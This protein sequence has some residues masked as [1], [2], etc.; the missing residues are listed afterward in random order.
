[1]KIIKMAIS[2]NGHHRIT[3]CVFALALAAYVSTPARAD[4]P[5]AEI[6][7]PE[8]GRAIELGDEAGDE[9]GEVPLTD[10]SDAT[11]TDSDTEAKK[12]RD[13]GCKV[14]TMSPYRVDAVRT[15]A[16]TR[17]CNT[18]SWLDSLFGD[19]K[20]FKGKEFRGKISLGF[21]QDELDGFEP[22]LRVRIKTDLPNVSDRLSA[23]V[24][25]VDDD[26]YIS[27]TE[28]KGDRVNNVGL[29]SSDNAESE[30]LIGLGY[31]NPDKNSNGF[32]TSIGA[33][34]SSGLAPYAKVAYRYLF[35]PSE[36]HY[37]H[38]T[39]TVFWRK[40]DKSGVSSKLDYTYIIGDHDIMEWD[41]NI[42]YTEAAEQWEWITSTTWH[43][44]FTPT[45]GI[46]SRVYVR[47][48]EEN[49]V[50][51]PEYGLT[52]TY[53]RPFLREWLSIET[54]VDIRWEK[55]HEH[56]RYE[57]AIRFGFQFEMLLGDYYQRGK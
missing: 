27:N 9:V 4:A 38:T 12:T 23:F 34:L 37:W 48:E 1:M 43:H 40:Q 7:E 50:A 16:H 13:N 8:P 33:K 35:N 56:E 30:W 20:Q 17:L 32:D 26:S 6:I 49:P 5:K 55:L 45:T 25:R 15:Q 44:E 11:E 31:R 42:K 19:E 47:G 51:I 18:A 28:A 10:Q 57:N 46:S 14:E 54:G 22:K 21:R 29:R 2:S 52:F 53:V 24:G 3:L 39:Q 41:T 36:R